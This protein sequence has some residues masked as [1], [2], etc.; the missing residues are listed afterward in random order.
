MQTY[1][2]LSSYKAPS[3]FRTWLDFQCDVLFGLGLKTVLKKVV[4]TRAL[5]WN[6][7]N[8]IGGDLHIGSMS[9]TGLQDT[10]FGRQDLMFHCPWTPCKTRHHKI[11]QKLQHLNIS[12]QHLHITEHLQIKQ[13]SSRQLRGVSLSS[14]QI[15]SNIHRNLQWPVFTMAI[16][17]K[18]WVLPLGW[19]S[20]H[21][22]RTVQKH[23]LL[24]ALE[25]DSRCI[26]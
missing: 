26:R 9:Q 5:Y 7:K 6:C 8:F 23:H 18:T 13:V 21:L 22:D 4:Y 2:H 24:T 1:Y 14:I 19:D 16:L 11:H 10:K 17:T 20:N 12:L 3:G 15:V 25:A